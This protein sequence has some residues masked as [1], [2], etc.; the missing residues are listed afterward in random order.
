MELELKRCFLLCCVQSTTTVLY[1]STHSPPTPS[2][3]STTECSAF[4]VTW[5]CHWWGG[6][7]YSVSCYV[8]GC[9]PRQ[10]T[11]KFPPLASLSRRFIFLTAEY[12][13]LSGWA[14]IYSP[15]DLKDAWFL[16]SSGS[17]IKL[18]SASVGGHMFPGHLSTCKSLVTVTWW[19]V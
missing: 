11:S 9:F 18:L 4:S 2:N 8:I 3:L 7:S 6:G 19:C 17:D 5:S 14:T 12:K 15:T 13:P 16:P 1:V 10:R